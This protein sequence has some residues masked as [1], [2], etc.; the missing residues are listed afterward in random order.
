MVLNGSCFFGCKL[1]NFR[2]EL[3]KRSQL[4]MQ[5]CVAQC[6]LSTLPVLDS[7]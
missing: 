5:K 3:H 7:T 1:S 4:E 6:A 2:A